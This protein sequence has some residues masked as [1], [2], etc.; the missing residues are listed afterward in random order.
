M[1]RARDPAMKAISGLVE[2]IR[3]RSVPMV[4][5]KGAPSR[6]SLSIDKPMILLAGPKFF[7]SYIV[8]RCSWRRAPLWWDA[9]VCCRSSVLVPYTKGIVPHYFSWRNA[10]LKLMCMGFMRIV[11]QNA[12]IMRVES[13]SAA[14]AVTA[15]GSKWSP[16]TSRLP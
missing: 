16:G 6:S 13:R 14:W 8:L 15:F 11:A 5:A 3:Y 12:R 10:L 2:S 1:Y 4:F 7:T 9:S